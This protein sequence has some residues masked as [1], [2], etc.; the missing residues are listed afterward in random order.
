MNDLSVTLISAIASDY[1][2]PG[3]DFTVAYYLTLGR[4]CAVVSPL[5][6][7]GVSPVK[8]EKKEKRFCLCSCFLYIHKDMHTCN[9][10][11]I[12]ATAYFRYLR[13]RL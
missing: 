5:P 7:H 13:Q 1:S 2:M 12:Q 4:V 9:V 10:H 11:V 6:A 8:L 3:F